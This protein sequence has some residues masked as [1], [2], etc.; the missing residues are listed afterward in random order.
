MIKKEIYIN[1]F[2]FI[3][4]GCEPDIEITLVKNEKYDRIKDYYSGW[5]AKIERHDDIVTHINKTFH[6]LSVIDIM[7]EFT[8]D[9]STYSYHGQNLGISVDRYE[10]LAVRLSNFK[11][12]KEIKIHE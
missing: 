12:D 6:I 10:E 5:Y 8:T 3:V 11:V 2:G 1:G 9:L 7:I 4:E